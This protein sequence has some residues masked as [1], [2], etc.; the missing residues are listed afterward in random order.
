MKAARTI[1]KGACV[2]SLIRGTLDD[3]QLLATKFPEVTTRR[4]KEQL[5][6]AIEEVPKMEPSLPDG[7]NK[8]L[9]THTMAV[10]PNTTI[11]A[12][13]LSTSGPGQHFIGTN[14]IGTDGGDFNSIHH[15]DDLFAPAIY[16]RTKEMVAHPYP[17]PVP[18]Q[19]QSLIPNVA[20]RVTGTG[21]SSNREVL[22]DGYDDIMGQIEIDR[23]DLR[24]VDN[25]FGSLNVPFGESKPRSLGESSSGAMDC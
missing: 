23:C 6:K 14:H 4:G 11:S 22:P 20:D 18:P 16:F 13:E 15:P 19:P 25:A 9:H 2:E 12:M 5:A 17:A 8:C 24:N 21:S 10:A 3:L 1:G 7:S